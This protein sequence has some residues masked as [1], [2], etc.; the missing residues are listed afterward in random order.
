MTAVR[1]WGRVSVAAA[2]VLLLGALP[3]A[4]ATS[5]VARVDL[6][7]EAQQFVYELNRA[8]W[9]PAR[10]ALES[11]S[12]M[13][14]VLPAPP[15]ALQAQL[16][17]SSTLKAN[18]MARYSYFGHHSPITD[19][20]PNA[21]VRGTGYPLPADWPDTANFVE[22]LHVGSPDPYAVL[23]SFAES[24][25]H[26][27][28]V[29]GERGFGTYTEIGVGHSTSDDYWAVH[30][31]RRGTPLLAVTGVVFADRDGDGRM[32][33]GEGLPGVI[34]TLGDAQAQ[35]N[36]GGGY[37]LP[38]QPGPTVIRAT[39]E[40]ATIEGRFEAGEYS[41]GVDFIAGRD[42]PVVRAYELC[43]G[44][45]PTILG[46]DGDDALVGTP[47]TDVIDGLGGNDV[48]DGRGGDDIICRGPGRPQGGDIGNGGASRRSWVHRLL[49]A[50]DR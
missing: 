35:T 48:I 33:P 22:S 39:I 23:R 28:H 26:R 42:R 50:W 17:Q 38:L 40:G 14:A 19:S 11:G 12:S 27:V 5:A 49:A 41:I 21:L 45:A 9:D 6:A 4:S 30:L 8:R 13:P 10:F 37:A 15:V 25:T 31:A 3:S 43:E 18:E 29:F 1:A 16:G 20:W 32:D 7:L 44:R 34:V 2:A 36:A 46:T 47:G 24:P